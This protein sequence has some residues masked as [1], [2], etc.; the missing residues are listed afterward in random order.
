MLEVLA[1]WSCS[2][3]GRFAVLYGLV[4]PGQLIVGEVL[5]RMAIQLAH[6][7]PGTFTFAHEL[8]DRQLREPLRLL[9]GP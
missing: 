4:S 5:A 8:V 1:S 9:F 3:G 6:A 7:Q 2:P